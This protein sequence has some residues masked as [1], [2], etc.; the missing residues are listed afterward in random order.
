[1]I[2]RD[3][4][5]S[6]LRAL[7][8][9]LEECNISRA[10]DRLNLTPSAVSRILA[11]LRLALNDPLLVRTSAGFELTEG[12]RAIRPHLVRV[13]D[14]FE[15][16]FQPVGEDPRHFRGTVKI[17]ISRYAAGLDLELA[18]PVLM[19]DAPEVEFRLHHLPAENLDKLETGA[20]DLAISLA[21]SE[22]TNLYA[23]ALNAG[24]W[25]CLTR[26]DHPIACTGQMTIETYLAARHLTMRRAGEESGPVDEALD[27]LNKRRRVA[28]ST[29][30]HLSAAMILAESDLVMTVPRWVAES[31]LRVAPLTISAAPTLLPPVKSTLFWH[32]RVHHAPLFIWLRRRLLE[33]LRIQPPST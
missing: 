19:K 33:V 3:L 10:A 28:L 24:E 31:L 30:G 23:A 14:E 4:T 13:L 29:L 1:M 6:A 9:L 11:R 12:A 16:L 22:S 7:R 32:A 15:R 2:P 27:S 5:P 26:V 18:L 25:V 17:G 20:I 8:V 21:R